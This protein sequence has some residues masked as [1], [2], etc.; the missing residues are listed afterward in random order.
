MQDTRKTIIDGINKKHSSAYKYLYDNYYASLC[1]YAKRFLAD[2][3]GEEDVVQDIFV[4]VWERDACFDDL[5]GLSAYLYRA[6][7]NACLIKLR[8]NRE[9]SGS[10]LELLAGTV[11]Y[12]STDNERFLIQEEYYRQLYVALQSLS[13]QRR[14]IILLSLQGRKVEEI[15]NILGISV[16]TVKTLKRKTYI[17][18]RKNLIQEAWIFFGLLELYNSSTTLPPFS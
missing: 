18:L 17:Y 2:M 16:N 13:A 12:D 6:V 7:H 8:D 14:K 11:G 9:L 3:P 1:R 5:K 4:K 10:N 15:A